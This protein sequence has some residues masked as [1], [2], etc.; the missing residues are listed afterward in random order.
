MYLLNILYLLILTLVYFSAYRWLNKMVIGSGA[1]SRSVP[2]RVQYV[3]KTISI[4]LTITYLG[5]LSLVLGINYG[6]VTIFLSSAFAVVGIAL[7]AQWSIL[8]NLTA[9]LIIFF[10]F[11]YRIGD[12]VRVLDKDDSV[13][14]YIEEITLFSVQ[15]RD[16]QGNLATY[17]NNLFLQRPV[18]KIEAESQEKPTSEFED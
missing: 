3:K 12:K 6:E 15:L 1:A 10:G 17:P 16:D 5:V 4:A 7:F 8:S 11:P 14:G 18:V 2:A 9:S 13:T